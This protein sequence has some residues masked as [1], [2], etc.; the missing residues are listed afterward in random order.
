[1]RKL[2]GL[3]FLPAS[4]FIPWFAIFPSMGIWAGKSKLNYFIQPLVKVDNANNRRDFYQKAQELR[5]EMQGE[6]NRIL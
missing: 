2:F 6:I 3:P 5:E 1:M 4:P